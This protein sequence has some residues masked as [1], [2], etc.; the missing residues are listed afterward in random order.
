MNYF[1]TEK[2]KHCSYTKNNCI[3]KEEEESFQ[4]PTCLNAVWFLNS[5][6]IK[7][8]CVNIAIIIII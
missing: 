8:L 7:K 5:I 6:N 4:R 1:F 2:S 3:S